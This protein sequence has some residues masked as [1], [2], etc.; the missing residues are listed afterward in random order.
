[1][2]LLG[3]GRHKVSFDSVIEVMM[4]DWGKHFL[5]SIE[6]RAKAAL[7]KCSVR[8]SMSIRYLCTNLFY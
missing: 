6:K 2:A 4:E 7:P 3:D 1:M 8:D 5:P